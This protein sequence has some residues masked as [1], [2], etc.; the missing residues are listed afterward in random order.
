MNQANLPESATGQSTVSALVDIGIVCSTSFLFKMTSSCP[1][2]IQ[3]L[4][5]RS[6]RTCGPPPPGVHHTTSSG[7][8]GSSQSTHL[9][10]FLTLATSKSLWTLST[11]LVLN[12]LLSSSM[13]LPTYFHILPVVSCICV[14]FHNALFNRL[15]HSRFKSSDQRHLYLVLVSTVTVVLA[16]HS[17]QFTLLHMLASCD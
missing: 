5:S 6:A 13:V 17:V 16:S 14:L 7:I 4:C 11:S 3:Q 8:Q 9:P 12:A 10:S 1:S 15:L 2:S